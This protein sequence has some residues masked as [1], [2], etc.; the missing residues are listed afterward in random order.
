MVK[1]AID[2]EHVR[3]INLLLFARAALK[4]RITKDTR[5]RNTPLE[6]MHF[7]IVVILNCGIKKD[8]AN[9]TVVQFINFHLKFLKEK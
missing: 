7:A 1:R 8:S 4:F 3:K 6:V 5:L 9:S 2:V